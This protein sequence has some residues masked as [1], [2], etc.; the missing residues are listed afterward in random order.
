MAVHRNHTSQRTIRI[1]QPLPVVCQGKSDWYRQVDN[2]Y[3][4]MLSEAHF[5]GHCFREVP[6]RFT[7]V[8]MVVHDAKAMY[9][10][11]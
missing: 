11:R 4:F 10:A 3:T 1:T 9:V 8:Q 6:V 2:T 5:S 7:N